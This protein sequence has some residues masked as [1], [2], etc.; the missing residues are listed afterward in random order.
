MRLSS[1]RTVRARSSTV[2]SAAASGSGGGRG[3]VGWRAAPAQ[4]TP[5]AA[6]P[7]PVQSP[8]PLP[9]APAAGPPLAPPWEDEGEAWV[10]PTIDPRTGRPV[11]AAEITVNATVEQA[12]PGGTLAQRCP[13]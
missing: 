8:V 1:R 13:Y 2:A 6:P 3:R 12:S 7:L 10:M 5:A 9:S 4:P 11:L